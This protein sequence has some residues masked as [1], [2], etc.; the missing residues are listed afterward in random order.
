MQQLALFDPPPRPDWRDVRWPAGR[1]HDP[2]CMLDAAHH[3]DTP[4]S[5]W[6]LV[7]EPDDDEEYGYDDEYDSPVQ[8]VTAHGRRHVQSITVRDGVL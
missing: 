1:A 8:L 5:W 6:E 3:R 2:R 4:C 7:E